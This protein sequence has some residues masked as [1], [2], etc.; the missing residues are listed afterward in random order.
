VGRDRELRQIK[1][2]FHACAD[3]SRAQLVSITGI[4]GIGKSR[5]G[6][7]FYKYFDGIAQ[8]TYW[9]RGRC[10][11]YGE[12]VTYWALAD[13]VRM[14]ARI[15]EDEDP[16]SAFVKLAAVVEEHIADPEERRFVEPRLRHL[17]G[18]EEEIGRYEREDLFAA[19][20]LFFERLAAVYPAVM[21]F[22]DMQ[23]ADA[24]ILDF[25]EYLLEW[26]RNSPIFVVTHARPE[27]L[28][29]RP[30]WGAGHRNFSSIYLEP[31]SEPAMEE[32]LN[33]LVP[34]LPDQLRAQI[35]ERSEGV[36]LYAVE[37]VRMLLDR[38]ALVQEG[39]FYRPTGMVESLEVPETLHALI[40][41]RLDGL[42]STERRVVQDAAVLGKTFTKQALAFMT[43]R[44]EVELKPIL[45]SLTRKEV[46]GVQ[47]DPRSPEHGQYGFLQDLLRKVAYDT[48][49]K[50]DRKTRHLAAAAHLEQ[51]LGEQEVV[52]V[53]ASHYLDAYEAAPDAP[54]AAE[55]RIKAG[56][57]LALAGERAASLGANEEAERYFAQAAGLADAPQAKAELHE[58]AGRAAWRAARGKEARDYLD[59]ALDVFGAEGLKRRTARISA[60]LA[61]V[62]YR[63]GHPSEAVARLRA[64]HDALAGEGPDEDLAAIAAQLGRFLVLNKQYDEAAPRLELALEL[65]EALRLAEVFCQALTT[66]SILYLSGNR[67]D[68]SRILLEGALERALAND[69][70]GA[71][72]RAFNNLAVNH[73]SA[74]RYRDA[75][76]LTVRGIELARRIGD[77][78]W[79]QNFLYGALSSLVLLGQWD[80]ALARGAGVEAEDLQSVSALLVPLVIVDCARGNLAGA[81][82]RLEADPTL[83][84]SED[85]QARLGYRF[86][87]A[88]VLRA[89]GKLEQSLTVAASG[90]DPEIGT[91]FLPV[92]LCLVEA[93]E[94]ASAL[95]DRTKV[96]ELLGTIAGLR[97]GERP[98]LVEA[99]AHRFQSKL[100]GDDSGYRA[101][102]GLFRELEMPFWLAV[103]LLEHGEATGSDALLT[104]AREIFE[105]L[106]AKPWLERLNSVQAD[107]PAK[108]HA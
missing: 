44:S 50:A 103:T 108:I 106:D 16:G 92:K 55:I 57:Q 90:I 25:I 105:R 95:G 39:S 102:A 46:F 100:V 15:A 3:E 96:E 36:P 45:S 56:E 58:N 59:R 18:L 82:G 54:D 28:E 11:S 37:T 7:E 48:L 89:E 32:L 67:I 70:H 107:T 61:E 13:M 60:I 29:R 62:D 75:M 17:L 98:P 30:N 84:S 104:E 47:A 86:A 97:P 65:A 88:H 63:E 5:L 52:E 81:R 33:G 26:A 78:I 87:E 4:A 23:W 8:I 64:A 31:L 19:W 66:K 79:E 73:E 85:P 74:D 41:A 34:G 22:E 24:S 51:A 83:K 101:A 94:S 35:L 20:R 42:P 68:E 40:A 71:A 80:E 76:D 9:H 10:L 91:T 6:W 38:G 21:V 14:R 2:L 53:V 69:L 27:L 72:V 1:E 99:H 12:G 49:A 77:R 93:L 43:E